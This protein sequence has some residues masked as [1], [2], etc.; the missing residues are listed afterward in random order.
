[1]TVTQEQV[2]SDLLSA[3]ESMAP[4]VSRDF[5]KSV[6]ADCS[7]Q[8]KAWP[9]PA[10]R[11]AMDLM[12]SAVQYHLVYN[13]NSFVS[14]GRT[15]ALLYCTLMYGHVALQD[16]IGTSVLGLAK[17]QA[18]GIDRRTMSRA[19][20]VKVASTTPALTAPS[21]GSTKSE[22]THPE[23]TKPC[24]LRSGDRFGGISASR[25]ATSRSVSRTRGQSTPSET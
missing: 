6:Q 8:P 22:G 16:R 9:H 5:T 24:G 7:L 4:R 12:N 10:K 19:K 13:S 3:D 14:A 25:H 23:P 1:M 21:G 18:F 11:F 17:S 2:G 15:L 20:L